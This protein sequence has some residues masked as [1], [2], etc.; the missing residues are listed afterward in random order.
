MHLLLTD[1]LAC[2]RCGPAFGLILLSDRMEDRRVLEGALGCPNC[3]ERYPVRGG[4]ADLRPPPRGPAPVA[5]P[6]PASP[7]AGETMRLAAMLGITEGPAHV[8]AAGDALHHAPA[9]SRLVPELEVLVVEPPGIAWEESPGVTRMY[10]GDVLPLQSR[11]LRGVVLGGDA[12]DALL[13]EGIR[14]LAS[15]GRLVV[16]GRPEGVGRRLVDAGLG[17][18]LDQAGATVATRR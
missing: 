2:P 1:R 8:L 7:D 13:D 3:R 4:A 11:S 15:G 10:V 12:V 18:L 9:L 5:A 16:L 6:S 17:L 14:V